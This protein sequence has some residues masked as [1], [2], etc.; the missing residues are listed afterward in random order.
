MSARCLPWVSP[1]K[2]EETCS[3]RGFPGVWP[4]G[5]RR[6]RVRVR[7]HPPTEQTLPRGNAVLH[8]ERH[9][10]RR[11]GKW[12]D[13]IR[14]WTRRRAGSLRSASGRVERTYRISGDK[15]WDIEWQQHGRTRA[16]FSSRRHLSSLGLGGGLLQSY[17]L[18]GFRFDHTGCAVKMEWTENAAGWFCCMR[19]HPGE[20][21]GKGMVRC[22]PFLLFGGARTDS[23]S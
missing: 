4:S 17:A 13:Y 23:W 11:R 5:Y 16:V 1:A 7:I 19:F 21:F 20:G 9:K 10:F 14:R 2:R 18:L 6:W 22:F 3:R 15:R 12:I 8:S